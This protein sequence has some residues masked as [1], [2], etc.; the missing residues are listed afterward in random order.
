MK[1]KDEELRSMEER[2][3]ASINK[4]KLRPDLLSYLTEESEKDGTNIIYY[5]GSVMMLMDMAYDPAFPDNIR[6]TG[7]TDE[8]LYHSSRTLTMAKNLR[9]VFLERPELID[10][11]EYMKENGGLGRF[12][13]GL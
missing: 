5:L 8:E 10:V 7:L 2:F 6:M 3:G 11:V 13:Q 12:L 1:R 9:K 4:L